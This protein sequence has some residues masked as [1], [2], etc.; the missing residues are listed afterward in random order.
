MESLSNY[1][2]V[3]DTDKSYQ[4]NGLQLR[5]QNEMSKQHISSA[6]QTKFITYCMTN[7]AGTPPISLVTS[8]ATQT[9]KW[10]TS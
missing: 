4:C 3:L 6:R 1:R 9:R 5:Q 10:Q 2:I 8:W 7:S